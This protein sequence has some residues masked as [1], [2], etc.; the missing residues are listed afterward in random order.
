MTTCQATKYQRYDC[1]NRVVK[2]VPG[3]QCSETQELI[4]PHWWACS[5]YI[6]DH[7]TT[8]TVSYLRL[9]NQIKLNLVNNNR[10]IRVWFNVPTEEL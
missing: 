7:L 5:A 2:V 3:I 9:L 10:V 4:E 6:S 8:G 1:P